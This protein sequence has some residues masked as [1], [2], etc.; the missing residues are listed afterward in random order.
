MNRTKKHLSYERRKRRYYM[1]FLIPFLAGFFILFLGIYMN[2]LRFSFN[3][4]EMKG[5]EGFE[6]HFVGWK[7]Y[8]FAFLTDPDYINN[9][10][11]SV[12]GMLTNIPL[13]ILYSLLMAVILNKKM[14]GR[15]AFRAI[16]FIP[17]ILATGFVDKAD[18]FALIL[19]QQWGNIGAETNAASAVANGL[20]SSMEI[21]RYLMQL[22]FSPGLSS[23]IISAVDS[24]FNIVNLAGVQMMIFLAGLQSIPPSVYEASDIDGASKWESFWL[25][26]FPMISPIIVVNI[27]YTM[28]DSLTKPQN[29]IMQQ[30][31]QQSFKANSMGIASAMAWFYFAVIAV[32]ILVVTF[33]VQ[34]Y[35][36]YQQKD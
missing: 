36:Y 26:T 11:N 22:S 8:I 18:N 19:T 21:K 12:M 3:E 30:I 29:V 17:V 16:F 7:N 1:V 6:L 9:V 2:S 10:K 27:I 15:T 20:I 28:V 33:I 25:I 4:I 13:V 5:A 31:Q 24:I 14:K 34:R 32:S 35:V 23:Y